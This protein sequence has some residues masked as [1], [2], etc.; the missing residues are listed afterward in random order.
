L[1]CVTL[2][3]EPS[4]LD[5]NR[6]QAFVGAV[7]DHAANKGWFFGAF[8][9]N[10]L[11]RSDLVEVAWQTLDEVKPSPDQAHFHSSSVE[12]NIVIRGSMSISIDGVR[13]EL[14]SG[15]CYIIW[16]ESTVSDIE[17]TKETE[18]IVIRAPSIPGD[19]IPIPDDPTA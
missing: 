7:A 16:P 1:F 14:T 10:P 15:Q 4:G 8:M 17:T 2:S 5:R 3:D 6:R 19:K 11:L 9:D 13:H 12:I 18:L